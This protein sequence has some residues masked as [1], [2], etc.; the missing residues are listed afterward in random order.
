MQSKGFNRAQLFSQPIDKVAIGLMVVLSIAIAALL[1]LGDRTRP[2]VREFSWQD[3]QVEAADTAFVVTFNRPMDRESV[4]TNLNITPELPG[5]IS[6]AGRRMAYTLNTPAVYGNEYSIELNNAY[7]RFADEVGNHV[8]IAPFVAKFS[9]PVPL[10]AYIGA[11]DDDAGRLVI[12]DQ[13]K[14]ERLLLSPANLSVTDFRI[15]GDRKKILFAAVER[16]ADGSLD[17]L[18]QKI[19]RVTTGLGENAKPAGEMELILDSQ[20]YQNFKF[21]LSA[22]DQII[23]VQRLDKQNP[24]RYGLWLMKEGESPQPLNNEPG[25]DFMITPDS[26][27]VAIAQGEGVAILPLDPDAEPLDFLPRFGT[28]LSF[29]RDGTQALTI[30]FNKDFTRSLFL[31]TNQGVQEELFITEGSILGAQFS[32]NK[33]IAYCLLTDLFQA[34]DLYREVPYLAAIDLQTKQIKR[35]IDLPEQQDLQI[36]LAPDGTA[37]AFDVVLLNPNQA[38]QS[39]RD[40][41]R[42]RDK[43][44]TAT[45]QIEQVPPQLK[46]LSLPGANAENPGLI[47]LNLVGSQPRWLP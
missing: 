16:L 28:V 4:A 3:Q 40:Y 10:L 11:A 38:N 29:S 6:W 46:L 39:Y 14:K 27:A 44:D 35:L 41:D 26:D 24:G 22:N 19:Y 43:I 21:D 13:Q 2:E 12:Y 45:G 25:G 9:T 20:E 5:R 36:S 18:E 47:S 17:V 8:P 23:V 7:D 1:L 32:P 15:Y 34:E 31:V 30:K 42:N 33:K 37:I